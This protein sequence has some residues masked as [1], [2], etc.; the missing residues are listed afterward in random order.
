VRTA[1]GTPS[2]GERDALSRSRCWCGGVFC[3]RGGAKKTSEFY[4]DTH[5]RA[6]ARSVIEFEELLAQLDLF[7]NADVR[8]KWIARIGPAKARLLRMD[9]RTS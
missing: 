1:S 7:G 4:R 6:I 2:D 9:R 3:G 5:K 8:L